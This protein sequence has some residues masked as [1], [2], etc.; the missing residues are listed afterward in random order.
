[1]NIA[2]FK[3][4][5]TTKL[6]TSAIAY[7]TS[8]SSGFVHW[9]RRAVLANYSTAAASITVNVATTSGSSL[10]NQLITRNLA[11]GETYVCPELSGMVL[12]SGEQVYASCSLSSSVNLTISGVRFSS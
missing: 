3:I 8:P 5:P 7:G 10:S 11:I 9:I 12:S 4:V 6:T 2:A 1:M